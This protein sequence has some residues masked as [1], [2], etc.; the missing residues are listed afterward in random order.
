MTAGKEGA[1]KVSPAARV[2][3]LTA[4]ALA[5]L[6]A[7]LSWLSHVS[8]RPPGY[9]LQAVFSDV[10]GLTA[11]SKVMLMGVRI[12]RVLS[13]TP[14]ARTVHVVLEIADPETRI[15]RDAHFKIL[16]SGLIGDKTLEIFPPDD[17]TASALLEADATVYGDAPA[18]LGTAME[19]ASKA[20]YA[21]RDMANSP[22]TRRALQAG[23]QTF[24]SSFTDLSSLIRHTDQVALGASRFVDSADALAGAIGPDDLSQIVGDLGTL[25]RGL[26]KAY[27]SLAGQ[28][29]QLAD[30][31]ETLANLR[32]LTARLETLAAEAEKIATDPKL[33]GD[34]K[35]LVASSRRVAVQ[36]G[37][38]AANPPRLSPRFDLG[39]AQQTSGTRPRGDFNVGLRLKDDTFYGG[40][41]EIGDQNLWNLWWGKPDFITRGLGFHLGMVRNKIGA[42]VDWSPTTSF[43]L[44]AEAYDPTQPGMR[45]GFQVYPPWWEH[46]IGITGSWIRADLSAGTLSDRFLLGGQWR[47]L[48]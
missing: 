11:G 4:L 31:R 8:F 47:P 15:F 48:D 10:D 32:S 33:Q 35:D 6:G 41:E 21:L 3:M 28:G 7:S 24:E 16:A 37:E 19:E 12:G 14:R 39:I 27:Q 23:L 36:A 40:I 45:L 18:R 9:H 26:R 13:V 17:A 20:L 43:D 2:G 1:L 34:V 38:I 5:L 22:A 42:G 29:D 30:A 25:T 44:I 46:R